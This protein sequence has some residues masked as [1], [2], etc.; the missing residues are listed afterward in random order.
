M[1]SLDGHLAEMLLQAEIRLKLSDG[2]KLFVG[3]N[4]V[5]VGVVPE[6][7]VEHIRQLV[8]VLIQDLDQSPTNLV[9]LELVIDIVI[10]GDQQFV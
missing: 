2:Y 8:I 3:H 1:E 6:H 9:L 10:E 4:A 5:P 7:I